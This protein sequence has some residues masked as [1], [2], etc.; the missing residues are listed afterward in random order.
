MFKSIFIKFS[1]NEGKK[2]Q[3][4]MVTGTFDEVLSAARKLYG[5]QLDDCYLAYNDM[6]EELI[7]MVCEEDWKLCLEEASMANQGKRIQKI[8]VF[9]IPNNEGSSSQG[10]VVL[11]DLNLTPEKVESEICETIDT[12]LVEGS[13][14]A[15]ISFDKSLLEEQPQ[16]R[17]EENVPRPAQEPSLVTISMTP[18][19]Q[20]HINNYIEDKLQE[21]IQKSMVNFKPAKP[22]PTKVQEQPQNETQETS[23]QPVVHAGFSCNNCGMYPIVGPRYH[24]LV[25]KDYDLCEHC[26]KRVHHEHP[27]I[28]FR[29]TEYNQYQTSSWVEDWEAMKKIIVKYKIKPADTEQIMKIL[30]VQKS[31]SVGHGEDFNKKSKDLMEDAKERIEKIEEALKE[32]QRKQDEATKW[33]MLE[34]KRRIQ[35][36]NNAMI[37]KRK[38][39]ILERRQKRRQEKDEEIKEELK[40]SNEEMIAKCQK[41]YIEKLQ[42]EI[43]QRQ[44]E[45]LKREEEAKKRE[46]EAVKR[47]DEAMKRMN[48]NNKEKEPADAKT[49][50]E[51]RNLEMVA[52]RKRLYM[53]K[54]EKMKLQKESH[55]FNQ[56]TRQIESEKEAVQKLKEHKKNLS[57]NRKEILVDFFR[58]VKEKTYLID[59]KKCF[60]DN[61]AAW[62]VGG[63]NDEILASDLKSFEQLT[64]K[65]ENLKSD[66]SAVFKKRIAGGLEKLLRDHGVDFSKVARKME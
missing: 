17:E 40:K 59:S 30:N 53:E 55:R 5:D 3:A 37:A 16:E 28:R 11:Q 64:Q 52:R 36:R 34:L 44:E 9:L 10:S 46:E 15:L 4:K 48:E 26:E 66:F 32:D 24:S 20:Q 61:V 14:N 21:Q 7:T 13:E 1:N 31:K 51:R 6:D 54:L 2:R 27:M 29:T 58:A 22:Q 45:A 8:S 23:K 43:S 65:E 57:T 19:V 25:E 12:N 41:L 56:T 42:E 33:K 60:E 18:E 62:F 49:R 63:L 39:L 50:I 47:L 35:R 38:R